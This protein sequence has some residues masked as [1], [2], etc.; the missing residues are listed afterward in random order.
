M[1]CSGVGALVLC[2]S[3]A[4]SRG[5]VFSVLAAEGGVVT[6]QVTAHSSPELWV[7]MTVL[8]VGGVLSAAVTVKER[9]SGRVPAARRYPRQRRAADLSGSRSSGS[10][11][12]EPPGY[13]VVL[14]FSDSR[15]GRPL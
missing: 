3:A 11:R 1:M 8:V 10:C 12:L 15:L 6:A 5:G 4:R 14:V 9:P 13:R 2:W 7:A